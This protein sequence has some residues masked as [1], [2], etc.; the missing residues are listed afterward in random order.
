MDPYIRVLLVEQEPDT[1]SVVSLC[2][3][4]IKECKL[5]VCSSGEEALDLIAANQPEMALYAHGLKGRDSVEVLREIHSRYPSVYLIVSLPDD[6]ED[7]L[8]TYMMAGTNDC[9]F[10]DKN[11]V[12]NLLTAVKRALIRISERDCFDLPPMS[13]AES[14][15]I[16][17]TLPDII[18]SLDTAGKFIHVNPAI[19]DVL[20]YEPKDVIGLEFS[21]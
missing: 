11:Y 2:L 16:D 9:L 20:G 12:Q 13:R 5:E 1:I 21:S 6:L 7:L 17:Q 19:S 10:K 14:V 4:E 3:S 15:A 8:D 18:F